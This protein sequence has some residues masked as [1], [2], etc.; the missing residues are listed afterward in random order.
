M[1][2]IG[3]YL[4]LSGLLI[5][6]TTL[7]GNAQTP[8]QTYLLANGAHLVLQPDKSSHFVAICLLVRTPRDT[9]PLQRAEGE[10]VAHALLYGSSEHTGNKVERLALQTGDVL[11]LL[12][13][14]DFVAISCLTNSA[15]LAN[16][17]DM[18][19]NVV[20][21]ADFSPIALQKA[22]QD[23]LHERQDALNNPH[24][25]AIRTAESALNGYSEPSEA[26]LQ[27][28][29]PL[30]AKSYFQRRYVPQAMVI[31]VVGNFDPQQARTDFEAFMADPGPNS[32]FPPISSSEP[33]PCPPQTTLQILSSNTPAAYAVIATAA[34]RVDNPHYPAFLVLQ[35]LLGIGHASRLFVKLRD[36]LGIGYQVEADYQAMVSGPLLL[37][38]EWDAQR[39]SLTPLQVLQHLKE[40]M[41]SLFTNPPS[42][43][44]MQRARQITIGRLALAQ[45]RVSDRALLIGWYTVMGLGA[46]Y[47]LKLPHLIANITRE[48]VLEVAKKYL[49]FQT[50]VVVAP[51]LPVSSQQPKPLTA[52]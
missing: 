26:L 1:K 13:T 30:S 17:A 48:D 24:T 28:V 4:A 37:S 40:Q 3:A 15:Q 29:T 51:N 41:K 42:H 43:V 2:P 14:P 50:A 46:D 5:F 21:H 18:L 6:L 36:Q 19:G 22:L 20:F 8:P 25:L 33:E 16:A 38:I 39:I 27:Q 49:A 10:M 44:A 7:A 34:P 31:S 45:E 47:V 35:A 11:S 9:T 23:I 12:H 52:P 32:S